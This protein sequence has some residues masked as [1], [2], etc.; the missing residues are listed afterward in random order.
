MLRPSAVLC[1]ELQGNAHR[2]TSSPWLSLSPL[3]FFFLHH[4]KS[5]VTG[6]EGVSS[7]GTELCIYDPD[8]PILTFFFTLSGMFCKH[9]P[10]KCTLPALNK[11]VLLERQNQQWAFL[12]SLDTVAV[13][14]LQY[15]QV[16][17]GKSSIVKARKSCVLQK[18]EI[19]KQETP[20]N[21][22]ILQ[23]HAG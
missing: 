20:V 12:C 2:I 9:N 1:A 11:W 21:C 3:F 10:P 7:E 14:K 16:T 6:G 13:K 4:I 18:N 5:Q 23:K 19:K 22:R 17:S 8:L 15:W